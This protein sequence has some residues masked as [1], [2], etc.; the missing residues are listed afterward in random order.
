VTK[1]SVDE[2]THD[3]EES[4]DDGFYIRDKDIVRCAEQRFEKNEK[5]ASDVQAAKSSSRE[6]VG[7]IRERETVPEKEP[8]EVQAAGSSSQEAVERMEKQETVSEKETTE[9]QA[10]GS[11]SQEAVG[12][13]DVSTSKVV[14]K[15]N[16][17]DDAEDGS[18]PPTAAQRVKKF[19]GSR[20]TPVCWE[21][22]G[23]DDDN[24]RL[25]IDFENG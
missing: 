10:A 14:E 1:V 6:A 22:S 16:I 20:Q 9:V 4:D 8:T 7:Q 15:R 2:S 12:Q 24:D 25:L 3:D 21:D 19:K 23:D 11:S 17:D 18:D 5:E 13:M